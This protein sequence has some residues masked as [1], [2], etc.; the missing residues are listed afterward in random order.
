MIFFSVLK[1]QNLGFR[2]KMSQFL[3]QKRIALV[4]MNT[5][6]RKNTNLLD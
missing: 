2:V 5:F 6:Q 3:G 1:C 4:M